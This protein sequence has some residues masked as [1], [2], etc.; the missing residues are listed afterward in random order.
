MTTP[1]QTI[2]FRPLAGADH[3]PL[4]RL[5][6]AL[7]N[8]FTDAEVAIASELMTER[9][10]RGEASGYEFLVAGPVGEPLAYSCYG[11]IPATRQRYDLYWIVVAPHLH[12]RG[13]GS[14]LLR[15]TEEDVRH[16]GGVR[17]YAQTSSRADYEPTRAFYLARGYRLEARI[18]DYYREGDGLCIYAKDLVGP[19][20]T[21][22]SDL[23]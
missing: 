11:A 22:V 3:E 8:F 10:L 20:E 18:D 21:P 2:L 13:L 17:L 15:A 19:R 1:T 5:T 16:R 23:R 4:R 14:A 7:E 12:G 6:R 9:L